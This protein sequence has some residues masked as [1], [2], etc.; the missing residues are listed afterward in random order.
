MSIKRLFFRLIVRTLEQLTLIRRVR[1]GSCVNLEET[2]GSFDV[3]TVAFNNAD[4]IPLHCQQVDKYMGEG[5]THIIA[6]NSSNKDT[7]RKIRQYCE[8]NGVPYVR[9]PKNY[10]GLIGGS[11]SHATALNWVYK[12]IIQKRK[13]EFFGFIDH[14]L[15]PVRP[16]HLADLLRKQH[17]Y[18]PKRKRGDYWY[19]SAIMS[20][21]ESSYVQDKKVD[22]MPTRYDNDKS[23]Y[24]DTG[25]SNWMSIYKAMDE[26]DLVFCSERLE[27]F[28]LG[29]ETGDD[30]YQDF[31]ELFD[32]QWV[33]TINGSYW[34]QIDIRKE[35]MLKDLIC[36]YES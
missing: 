14:D 34:K 22:F 7:S 15:F 12:R 30:R 6:D 21:F 29:D 10:L 9:V 11:Y 3:I 20:F 31:V 28:N 25:G 35:G 33:H 5:V 17:V 36:R 18:G 19:L 2:K 32:G 24:L 23:H 26:S 8:T 13:P 16:I 1:T 27:R 4:I